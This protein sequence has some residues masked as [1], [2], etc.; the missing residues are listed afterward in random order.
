MLANEID[1]EPGDAMA[2][3]A[4]MAHGSGS[5]VLAHF[6]RGSRNVPIAQMG[7]GRDSSASSTSS[8]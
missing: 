5:K 7:A 2:H 4:S 1:P 6:I 3:V 8:T